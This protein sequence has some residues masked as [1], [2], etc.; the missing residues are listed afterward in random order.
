MTMH[1]EHMSRIAV[2]GMTAMLAALSLDGQSP[3][4]Q[5]LQ[6]EEA[7]AAATRSGQ[8]R[9]QFYS[10][11]FINVNP[12][13]RVTL[14]FTPPA[15][16]NAAYYMKD[17]KV[18]V[19]T[20][21]AAV[22]TGLQGPRPATADV[23]SKTDP[24]RVLRVWANEGGT[25]KVVAAQAVWVRPALPPTPPKADVTNAPYSAKNP[26]EAAVAKV[27]DAINEAFRTRDVAGYE[28][29]TA[30]EFIRIS[31][32]GQVTPR[33]DFVKNAVAAGTGA[34]PGPAAN[35]VRTRVYGDVAVVT[36]RNLRNTDPMMR[37]FVNRGGA[38][39]AV[40]AISTIIWPDA[41][42]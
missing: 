10:A 5:I 12:P 15:Q 23:P 11:D 35:E 39:K 7:R 30:P 29:H 2:A 13:G 6:R 24:D 14:G 37:M 21:S 22:V 36:Y 18:I 16:P 26:A 4:D 25:W 28:S 27:N 42:K 33:A 17:V 31:S 9:E 34:R 32:F 20:P 41:P 38:W 19:A 8:G 3:S 1:A 40:A